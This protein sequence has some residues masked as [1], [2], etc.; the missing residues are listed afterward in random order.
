MTTWNKQLTARQNA[1]FL[2]LTVEI[3]AHAMLVLVVLVEQEGGRN[4]YTR[5]AIWTET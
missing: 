2:I 3:N 4:N 1:Y 5:K